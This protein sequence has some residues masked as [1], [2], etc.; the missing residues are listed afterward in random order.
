MSRLHANTDVYWRKWPNWWPHL[1]LC[2]M[3]LDTLLKNAKL[4]RVIQRNCIMSSRVLTPPEKLTLPPLTENPSPLPNECNILNPP[5]PKCPHL[6]LVGIPIT[7]F[8]FLIKTWLTYLPTH[9]LT[10]ARMHA[11]RHT[12]M[13]LMV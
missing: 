6:K 3:N 8:L 10:H 4:D 9:W 7:T 13:D 1:E 2:H 5:L 12:L 11:Y